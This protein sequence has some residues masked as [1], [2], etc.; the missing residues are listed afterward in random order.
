MP[1][2]D[3]FQAA[4]AIREIEAER[5]TDSGAQDFSPRLRMYALSGLA[6]PEDKEKA[7]AIGFDG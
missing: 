6:S 7:R 1:V 2:M 5:K 4:T 3:G